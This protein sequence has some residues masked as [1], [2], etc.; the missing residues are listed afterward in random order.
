ME[1]LH[2]VEGTEDGKITLVLEG[3]FDGGDL[4]GKPGRSTKT[5]R[6]NCSSHFRAVAVSKN[7]I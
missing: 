4:A 6:A 1:E 7:S 5:M 2:L 3:E